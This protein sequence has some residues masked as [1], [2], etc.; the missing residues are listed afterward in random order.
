MICHINQAVCCAMVLPAMCR[1]AIARTS[2][3]ILITAV[4]LGAM[5]TLSYSQELEEVTAAGV[6]AILAQ[7]GIEITGARDADVTIV[8]YFDYNCPYC[9]RLDPTF[10]QLLAAD[11]RIALVFKDWPVLGEVSEYAARCA[12]AAQWQGKYLEAHDALLYGPHLSQDDVVESVLQGAGIDLKRLKKDLTL[13]SREIT[14]LLARHDAEAHALQLDGTP[15]VLVGRQ[16]MPGGADLS[17]FQ[18]LV[19]EVRS[20]AK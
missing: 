19:G 5:P 14:A 11:K 6:K 15:G 20:E 7:P 18:R 3:L 4:L 2:Q 9:K 17:F 12:L 1:I 16:L 13:H 8:E 10:K